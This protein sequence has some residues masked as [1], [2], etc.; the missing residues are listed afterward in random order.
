MHWLA[1]EAI[2]LIRQPYGMMIG[3]GYG[4][5]LTFVKWALLIYLPALVFL[6]E[7]I[8]RKNRIT[9][10]L[11]VA[12]FVIL[13]YTTWGLLQTLPYQYGLLLF[14]IGSTIITRVLISRAFAQVD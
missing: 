12:W 8:I 14:S 11:H 3:V 13:C 1:F 2:R 5:T 10:L 7:Y 6:H 4:I 9:I